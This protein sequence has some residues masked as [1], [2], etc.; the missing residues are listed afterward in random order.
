MLVCLASLANL[1]CKKYLDKK[2]STGITVPTTLPD[3]QALLDNATNMNRQRTPTFGEASADDYFLLP[4]D[5]ETQTERDQNVYKWI[6]YENYGWPNDWSSCYVPVYNSN[7]CLEQIQKIQPTLQNQ[8]AWNNVKGSALFYRAYYFLQLAWTFAKAYDTDSAFIDPGIALRQ[9]SDI[10]VKSVRA[11]IS[12]TYE[13]IIEDAEESIAYLPDLPVHVNRPSKAAAYGLL[14]RTYLSMR[15]YDSAFKYADLCLNIQHELMDYNGDP[16]I[17]GSFN[18]AESP[19]K[20]FNKETIFY[21]EMGYDITPISPF[22][23]K[24]DTILL[25]L[26]ADDDLRKKAFFAPYSGY[27]QFKGSYTQDMWTPFTGLAT[28]EV[29]L[30]RAECY[31]RKNDKTNAL[32]D[33]NALLI[34]RYKSISFKPITATDNK[35]A[36]KVILSERRKELL[37][38]GLRFQDI[39]RL[40]KEGAG[41]IQKRLIAGQSFILYPNDPRYALPI[42]KEVIDNSGMSQNTY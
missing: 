33:L 31:A 3:M 30:I 42:P 14:A 22:Y 34:K 13:R 39:K 17:I 8:Q 12:E 29:Y 15:V 6:P 24:V 2:S 41:I 20:L 37:Y 25:A 1:G 40:N 4:A 10:N 38:R 18:D 7:Y 11:N 21:T 16:D 35:E 32:R 23:A 9:T 19:F 27:L 26:Y 5:Y 36:L 28:D